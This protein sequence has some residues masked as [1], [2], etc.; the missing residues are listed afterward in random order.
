MYP[1]EEKVSRS[2]KICRS[3][4]PQ[5]SADA[6]SFGCRE[7]LT[8]ELTNLELWQD[9]AR[10]ARR[11]QAAKISKRVK[12]LI[13]VS[14]SLL[15][16]VYFSLQKEWF[17]QIRSDCTEQCTFIWT[18]DQASVHGAWWPWAQTKATLSA[19]CA[20]LPFF[21]STSQL[22]SMRMLSVAV[23]RS[24]FLPRCGV[25]FG[26]FAVLRLFTLLVISKLRRLSCWF[27]Y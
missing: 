16:F 21:F 1:S 7:V 3:L 11:S 5:H 10:H 17:T 20:E 25:A 23:D 12:I 14:F 27:H 15:F 13:A 8:G 19:Q 26:D 24:L 6:C 4:L 18:V 9:S 2:L 22:C